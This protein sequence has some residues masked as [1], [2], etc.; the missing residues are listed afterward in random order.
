MTDRKQALIELRDKV[1]VGDQPQPRDFRAALE[2]PMQDMRYTVMPNDA[3]AAYGGSL[4]AAKALHDAVL[5]GW[6]IERVT[7][8]PGL[9]GECVVRIWGT[10]DKDGE[11]WHNFDDGRASGRSRDNLARAWLLAILEALIAQEGGDYD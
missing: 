10:H 3:R 1:R 4:D 6:A 7:M 2:V 8:W 11:R 5:P 9:N